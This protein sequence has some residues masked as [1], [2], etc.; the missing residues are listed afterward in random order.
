MLPFF[1]EQNNW[2]TKSQR[3]IQDYDLS[4]VTFGASKKGN[5]AATLKVRRYPRPC[6]PS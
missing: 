1:I 5:I 6:L 4:R 3:K 2:N